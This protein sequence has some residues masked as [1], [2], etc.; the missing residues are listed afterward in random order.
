MRKKVLIVA[1]LL[2]A[3]V[4]LVVRCK[5]N[6]PPQIS[7]ISGPDSI[8]AGGNCALTCTASDQNGDTL[9]YTWSCNVGG[10]SGT[11]GKIVT[12]YA[13]DTTVGASV[14]AIASDGKLADTASINIRVTPSPPVIDSI[15]GPSSISADGNTSLTCF[16]HGLGNDIFTYSWTCDRGQVTP[17]IGRTITW[18]A[19]DTSGDASITVTIQDIHG[20][21]AQCT[22][23]IGVTRVTTTWEDTTNMDIPVRSSYA[24]HGTWK[25]GYTASG[26]FSV[27]PGTFN[28]MVL[29]SSNYFNWVNNQTY[30]YLVQ[31]WGSSGSAFSVVIPVT[32]RYY[33]LLDN[34]NSI[35]T[36]KSASLFVY[37]TTP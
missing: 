18:N 33:F 28:F 12:W 23:A 31:Y 36:P 8:V 11:T 25:V 9:G 5:Q 21:T 16:A 34:T 17:A 4:G 32:G 30:S 19:P 10:L 13:P 14:T 29:D 6:R 37:M 2:A 24:F 1:L 3:T 7:S 20:N 26:S 15:S 27:S 22:K 35:F